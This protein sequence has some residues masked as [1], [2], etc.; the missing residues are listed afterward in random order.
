MQD[1]TAVPGRSTAT[2]THLQNVNEQP[3]EI[4]AG[5]S[6]D[7]SRQ[8]AP[9]YD[10]YYRAADNDRARQLATALGW[11]SIGIGLA[12]LLAPRGVSRTVGLNEQ[13]RL[14]RALGMREIASGVG[15]LSQRVPAGWLWARVAGDALDLALLGWAGRSSAQR[16]R[17]AL[18]TAAVAG[19]AALD[20]VSSID[21]TQRKRVE[22]GIHPFGAIRVEKSMAVNRSPQECYRFWHDF[23]SFPRFMKHVES[24]RLTGGNSMHWKVTGPAGSSV[25]WDAELSADEPD[26]YISWR[27]LGGADVDNIGSVRFEAGPGGRGTIVRVTLEYTPP[28]GP[29]G[30]LVAKMFGEEPSQQLD[31]DL[32]RFK[33]LIET[34]EIPTTI[35][36]SSGTRNTVARLLRKGEPG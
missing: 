22:E 13:P 12:Q 10:S 30:A 20:L 24:V 33:W 3:A 31:E 27:S 5:T 25:E 2:S 14:M 16:R 26:Q 34:G 11:F 23:E 1:Q 29:A 4:A 19:V 35:G 9:A 15:I 6:A 21:N 8:P 17:I 28:G 32:R 7:I 18:A 36:Q